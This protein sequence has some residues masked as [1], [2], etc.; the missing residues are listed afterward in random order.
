MIDAN[1]WARCQTIG[2]IDSY[3]VVDGQPAELEQRYYTSSQALTASELAM[4]ARL[5]W[6]VENQLHWVLD[7]NVGEDTSMVRKNNAPQNL[8]LRKKIVLTLVRNNTT[9]T[10]KARLRQKGKRAARDDDIRIN[11][12]GIQAL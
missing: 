9:D 8:S 10:T 3:R 1:L 7:V 2:R 5:H 12:L 6:A 11:M 4:A